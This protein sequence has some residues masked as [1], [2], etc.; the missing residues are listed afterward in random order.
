[1][2]ASCRSSKDVASSTEKW[3]FGRIGGFPSYAATWMQV[4]SSKERERWQAFSAVLLLGRTV[5]AELENLKYEITEELRKA[6]IRA[7]GYELEFRQESR[8]LLPSTA[9]GEQT[10][11]IGLSKELAETIEAARRKLISILENQLNGTHRDAQI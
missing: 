8:R 6:R 11:Q 10:V 9:T 2:E 4:G 7:M 5:S 1:M 3:G